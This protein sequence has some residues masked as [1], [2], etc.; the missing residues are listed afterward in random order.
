MTGTG[1]P[2]AASR[3]HLA[4]PKTQQLHATADIYI[5]PGD[6]ILKEHHL[7]RNPDP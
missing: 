5:R 2:F 4:I 3:A 7:N 6:E 1:T